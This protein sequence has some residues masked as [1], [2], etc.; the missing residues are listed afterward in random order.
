MLVGP[1][2]DGRKAAVA[3]T[4]P[5]SRAAVVDRPVVPGCVAFPTVLARP[6]PAASRGAAAPDATGRRR[7][8]DRTAPG[9]GSP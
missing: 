9:T 3:A 5:G 7:K 2:P 1:G 8:P 6:A 4:G